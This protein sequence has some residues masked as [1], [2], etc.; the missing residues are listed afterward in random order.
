M[1]RIGC[2]YV[3]QA[4]LSCVIL[5]FLCFQYL[6]IDSGPDKTSDIPRSGTIELH[7]LNI[8]IIIHCSIQPKRFKD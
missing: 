2:W 8:G 6:L 3:A 5:V 1:G 4:S 7:L